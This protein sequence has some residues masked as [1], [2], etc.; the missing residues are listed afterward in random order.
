MCMLK[1][2][3]GSLYSY[4]KPQI[5]WIKY[6]NVIPRGNQGW[7]IHDIDLGNNFLYLIPNSGNRIKS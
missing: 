6:L 1:N 2:E 3:N 7:K 4:K 5:I